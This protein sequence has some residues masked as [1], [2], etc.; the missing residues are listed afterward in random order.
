MKY[1]LMSLILFLIFTSCSKDEVSEQELSFTVTQGEVFTYDLGSN[2][3]EGSVMI[4]TQASNAERSEIVESSQGGIQ[5]EYFAKESFTGIDY[6]EITSSFSIGD[7][8]LKS[9]IFKISLTVE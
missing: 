4:T 1:Y 8:N 7:N 3:T 2:P 9:T 5:Y 6:V